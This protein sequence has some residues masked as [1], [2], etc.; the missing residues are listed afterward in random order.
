MTRKLQF[1]YVRCIEMHLQ[2]VNRGIAIKKAAKII[3]FIFFWL[4]HIFLDIFL[5]NI[6]ILRSTVTIDLD[7]YVLNCLL[8]L[9]F[10]FFFQHLWKKKNEEI[11]LFFLSFCFACICVFSCFGLFAIIICFL[12]LPPFLPFIPHSN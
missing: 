8:V 12:W 11:V 10:C 4:T 9:I 2:F 5:T 3:I 6:Y 7:T 1:T